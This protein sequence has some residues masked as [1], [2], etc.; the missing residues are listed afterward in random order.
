MP[1]GQ[2]LLRL[3][4]STMER[5]YANIY[6]QAENLFNV[7]RE[8]GAFDEKLASVIANLILSFLGETFFLVTRN[9]T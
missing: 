7:V 3:V 5:K 4:A 8:P 2:S 9:Q 1:L 6:S